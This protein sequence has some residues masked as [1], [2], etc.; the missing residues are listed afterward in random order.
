MN[1]AEL[2]KEWQKAAE[3]KIPGGLGLEKHGI[4]LETLCDVIIAELLGGGEV[5]LPG[6]G[7]LKVKKT[8][9]R[10]GRNPRTGA[11][12]TIAARRKAVFT[13]SKNLK[14]VLNA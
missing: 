5:T 12:L 8:V 10:E 14:E 6:L 11:A 7:K 2:I 9:A 4:L 13:E 1:K 3:K